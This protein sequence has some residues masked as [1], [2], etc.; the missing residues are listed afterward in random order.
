M[1]TLL[2][3]CLAIRPAVCADLH[4]LFYDLS[5]QSASTRQDVQQTVLKVLTAANIQA[6]WTTGD[7][8]APQAHLIDAADPYCHSESPSNATVAIRLVPHAHA[9]VPAGILGW[10]YPCA[11]TGVQVTVFADRVSEVSRQLQAPCAR[12]LGYALL[13]E[14]GHI[15]LPLCPHNTQGVM[16]GVWTSHEWRKA[17][18]YQL[19]FE[20]PEIAAIRLKLN[21]PRLQAT[22]A[23]TTG[24]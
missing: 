17:V 1:R 9:G 16:K 22:N 14:I 5:G 24:Q 18:F 15:L 3:L 2:L 11:R 21:P 19:Q 20:P 7:I 12:L 6:D 13:H 8:S 23:V 10:S 4:L